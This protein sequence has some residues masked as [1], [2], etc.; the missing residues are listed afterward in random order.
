MGI[1]IIGG[2]NSEEKPNNDVWFLRTSIS[3]TSSLLDGKKGDGIQYF[4]EAEKLNIIGHP[5]MR[6][7]QHS[8]MYFYKYIA[9]FGGRNDVDFKLVQTAAYNDLYLLDLG[10]NLFNNN[11]IT[12]I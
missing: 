5:P 6:R 10:M 4:A 8:A 3:T 7:A 9:I 2:M 11:K 12:F 1:Y